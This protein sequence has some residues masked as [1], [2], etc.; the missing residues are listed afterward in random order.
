MFGNWVGISGNTLVVDSDNQLSGVHTGYVF[1]HT[2][3][4]WRQ[5]AEMK[6]IGDG[7]DA[8]SGDR[9]VVDCGSLSNPQ[10]CVLADSPVGWQ[11]TAEFPNP[12]GE[13]CG[14]A[15]F[16][17]STI[18][19]ANGYTGGSYAGT[20]YAFTKTTTGWIKTA[21]L[22]PSDAAPNNHFGASAAISGNTIAIGAAPMGGHQAGRVY[23][24]TLTGTGWH[25]VAELR[26]SATASDCL[27]FS[28]AMSG[29]TVVAGAA[30]HDNGTGRAYVFQG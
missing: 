1:T 30:G 12:V 8:I 29:T 6:S 18:V 7:I 9:M 27:G 11:Q 14:V 2:D 21:Q 28:V 15:A 22:F 25:Q 17:G 16:F 3:N 19:C 10:F 24:F 4:G 23:L 20:A 26:G 5:T 13:N